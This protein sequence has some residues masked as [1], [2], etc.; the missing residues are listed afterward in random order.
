MNNNEWRGRKNILYID[1][2]SGFYAT[3]WKLGKIKTIL[4]SHIYLCIDDKTRLSVQISHILLQGIP[5]VPLPLLHLNL[6]IHHI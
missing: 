5:C 3:N 2:Y 6:T 4:F 1:M